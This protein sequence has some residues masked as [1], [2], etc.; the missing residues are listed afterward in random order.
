MRRM[1]AG[2]LDRVMAIAESQREAPQWPQSAYGT[3]LDA[4]ASPGRVALVVE[5]Q[6]TGTIAGFAVAGMIPPEAELESIAVA[7]EFQRQ[8]AA[9]ELFSAL[10]HVLPRYGVRETLLEVRASN[11]RALAFYRGLGFAVAG[12][13][14]GYYADPIEDAVVLR[15]SLG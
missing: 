13:R 9:K 11:W 12:S 14:P 6:A 15:L 8:G 7:A 2:D 4:E 10:T 1:T 3:A 5:D